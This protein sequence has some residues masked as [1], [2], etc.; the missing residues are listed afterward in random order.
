MD[1]GGLRLEGHQTGWS[2]CQDVKVRGGWRAH[3]CGPTLRVDLVVDKSPLLQ[4]G[5]DSAGEKAQ[6]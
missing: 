2:V 6:N 1:L 3:G 5:V 4:E